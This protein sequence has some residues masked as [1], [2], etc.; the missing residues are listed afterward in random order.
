MKPSIGRIVLYTLSERD[1]EGIRFLT[2]RAA[3]VNRGAVAPVGDDAWAGET[4]PAVIVSVAGPAAHET[5]NLKVWLNGTHD[6]WVPG[7]TEGDVRGT[8]H[9]PERTDG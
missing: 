9:W 7:A 2:D 8:W 4:Y 1:A 3:S 5:V 6:Y